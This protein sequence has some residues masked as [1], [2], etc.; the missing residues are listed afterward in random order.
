MLTDPIW[1]SHGFDGHGRTSIESH[2]SGLIFPASRAQLA[3]VSRFPRFF[4][5]GDRPPSAN[6]GPTSLRNPACVHRGGRCGQADSAYVRQHCF[7]NGTLI[8]VTVRHSCADAADSTCTVTI[9]VASCVAIL[10]SIA[11]CGMPTSPTFW[12]HAEIIITERTKVKG[13]YR[14]LILFVRGTIFI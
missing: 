12:S 14:R 7:S 5:P 10:M 6:F 2:S 3:T 8:F 4:P 1:K 13:L 9:Y 11:R